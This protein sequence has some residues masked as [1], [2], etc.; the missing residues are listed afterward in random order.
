M[1]QKLHILD[2]SHLVYRAYYALPSMNNSKGQSVGAVVGVFNIL[3]K[4][5]RKQEPHLFIVACDHPQKSFRNDLYAEYKANRMKCPDDLSEQF[6]YVKELL[7]LLGIKQ[8]EVPGFEADDIIATVVDQF[9][10]THDCVILSSDKDLMQLVNENVSMYDLKNELEIREEEVVKKLGVKPNQ[11]IDFLAIQGDSSDNIPGVFGV[12]KKRASTLLESY[13]TLEGI[14]ENIAELKGKLKENLEKEKDK[15]LLSRTL[16]VLDKNVPFECSDQELELDLS[17]T[18]QL[19]Q[20]LEDLETPRLKN[21]FVQSLPPS[22]E[23]PFP[24]DFEENRPTVSDRESITISENKIENGSDLDCFIEA[25]KNVEGFYFSMTVEGADPANSKI[26]T[27]SVLFSDKTFFTC[28]FSLVNKRLGGKFKKEL[29]KLLKNENLYKVGFDLKSSLWALGIKSEKLE[30]QLT[31]PFHDI[32]LM[33]HLLDPD[34]KKDDLELLTKIYADHFQFSYQKPDTSGQMELFPDLPAVDYS[35][36]QICQLFPIL[37]QELVNQELWNIYSK[38]ELPLTLVLYVM[39]SKGIVVDLD[40]LKEYSVYLKSVKEQLS[41]RI[42]QL[43]GE[44][45][46]IQSPKQ[47]S[48]ILFEKLELPPVKKTKTGYSTDTDVLNKLA[49]KHDLPAEIIR[50]RFI[51]KLK[52]TYV[53]PLQK[54]IHP[55]TKR[56]HTTFNQIG[57]GTGRLSSLKP[58]LQNIPIRSAEGQRVRN[59]FVAKKDSLIIAADY[60]QIELRVLAHCTKDEGMQDAFS[61]NKDIHRWTAAQVNGVSE[62]AVTSEM[63]RQAKA[64]NFGIIYGQTPFGLSEEIGISRKEA[65]NFI[66]QYFEQFGSIKGFVNESI[67]KARECGFSTT[68]MG[69]KRFIK[70]L[71]SQNKLQRSNAE[72]MVVNSAIQGTAAEIIKL[73]MIKIDSLL[74]SYRSS[75]ILQIHDELVF[76]VS[77]SEIDQVSLMVKDA[78][79]SAYPLNVPL[80]VNIESGNTW[81]E[82]H[83]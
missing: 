62:E 2:L 76:E 40:E 13:G 80:T 38:I 7:D 25:S 15:A 19:I 22:N 42:Y 39:E 52:S 47:L 3:F 37:K 60:S 75:M 44:E 83:S 50:F 77:R 12:G 14:Y 71:D 64:I 11:V 70:G 16:V 35:S 1:K 61:C 8:V 46:N 41:S 32:K 34:R 26:T 66:E 82:A 9:Q 29:I 78:M 20:K 5:I 33:A 21:R 4:Y 36:W 45:F 31:T 6:P 72:R 59:C 67:E 24:S 10:S 79:E 49:S 54:F 51:D 58:N 73:A 55:V 17:L 74:E 63:R 69:R 53:D 48:K 43:A 57:T 28:N 23:A 30:E 68:L 18:P 65:A 56:I 81:L 27:C